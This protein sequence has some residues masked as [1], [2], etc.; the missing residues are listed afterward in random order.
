MVERV[1]DDFANWVRDTLEIEDN[2]YL[3]VIALLTGV[4]A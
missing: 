3:R 1:F 2:P 4:K